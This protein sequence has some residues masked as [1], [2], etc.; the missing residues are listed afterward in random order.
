MEEIRNENEILVGILK[1][2]R[3]RGSLELDLRI[4]LK[5]Y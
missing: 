1:D 4:I 3:P 5:R 2:K